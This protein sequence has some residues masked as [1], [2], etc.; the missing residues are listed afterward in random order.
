MISKKIVAVCL[1]STALLV[2]CGSKPAENTE[3]DNGQVNQ[4]EGFT[5][6]K[7]YE[8]L[9]DSTGEKGDVTVVE[10]EFKDGKAT[11]ASVDVRQEDGSMKKQAAKDGKYVMKEGE[12]KNWAEQM[13]LV[14]AY[15]NENAVEV[16]KVKIT[17]DDGHTDAVSGVTIKVK[18]YLEAVQEVVTAVSEGKELETGFTGVKTVETAYD[19]TGD[20][21]D[22]VVTKV[23]FNH[24]KP[25]SVNFDVKQED[26]SMKKQVSADGKY[27]MKEGEAKR[28]DEQMELLEDFIAENNFD[29]SKVK[30]TN[31]DGNT[32]AVS[33]VSIKVGTYLTALQ[34]LLDSVK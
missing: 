17:D 22:M 27:V 16:S 3:V 34:E 31:D 9:Y 26:G 2:G 33:G 6:T 4:E 23:V 11:K 7:T 21:Q 32:D 25:V 10:V 30:L 14:E 15:L 19:P 5:G 18:T 13:E 24:G 20:K 12:A 28:W 1:L 29:L 8:T